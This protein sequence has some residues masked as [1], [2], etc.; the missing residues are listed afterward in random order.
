MIG[1]A[2]LIGAQLGNY[3]IQSLLGAGGM[4]N[5]YRGFDRNLR[6]PVAIKVLSDLAAQPDFAA[7]VMAMDTDA[8]CCLCRLSDLHEY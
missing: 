3:E 1:S 6:R 4:A 5:V 8:D 7:L 2:Q